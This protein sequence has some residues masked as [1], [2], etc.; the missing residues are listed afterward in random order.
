MISKRIAKSAAMPGGD[1][2]IAAVRG[3]SIPK[4]FRLLGAII[5]TQVDKEFPDSMEGVEGGMERR[6][7]TLDETIGRNWCLRL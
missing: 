4:D 2:R 5:E 1:S 7:W 6:A 3:T